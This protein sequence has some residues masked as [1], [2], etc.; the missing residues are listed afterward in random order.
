VSSQNIFLFPHCFLNEF[1]H[2]IPYL[3][4]YVVYI[5]IGQSIN[6]GFPVHFSILVCS[7]FWFLPLILSFFSYYGDYLLYV[8]C[9]WVKCISCAIVMFISLLF[10]HFFLTLILLFFIFWVPYFFYGG[11]HPS[12]QSLTITHTFSNVNL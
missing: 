12:S 1:F 10:I 2:D 6:W 11:F 9:G 3:V 5:V 7:F 4:A 8:Y